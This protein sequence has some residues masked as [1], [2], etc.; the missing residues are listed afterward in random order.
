LADL[1]ERLGLDAAV[2]WTDHVPLEDFSA[3]ARAADVCVQLRYPSN[4]ETSA[5]LL[6]ALA[7]GAACVASDQ[8]PML[9]LPSQAVWKVRSPHREVD[10][11]TAALTRLHD[12]PRQ[13]AGLAEAARRYAAEHLDPGRS[14][15]LYVAVIDQLI[16][17]RRGR[18]YHWEE[19][20]CNAMAQSFLRPEQ[21]AAAVLPPWAAL[22]CQAPALPPFAPAAARGQQAAA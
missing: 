10:D 9:E 6:R 20:V 4:G 11:L 5:A 1:A 16:G 15:A 3:Y 8:G 18:D 7:A 14:A 12:H 22:H 17:R 19:A 13:R 21:G 2:R